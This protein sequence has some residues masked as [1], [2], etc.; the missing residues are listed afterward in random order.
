MLQ[1][2]KGKKIQERND[3]L[4][5]YLQ[6]SI[7]YGK[8]T[9]D[10]L[11]GESQKSNIDARYKKEFAALLWLPFVVSSEDG[12]FDSLAA[13]KFLEYGE[14]F[15][16]EFPDVEDAIWMEK[17]CLIPLRKILADDKDY[18]ANPLKKKFYTG[19]LGLEASAIVDEYLAPFVAASI[20]ILRVGVEFFWAFPKENDDFWGIHLNYTLWDSRYLSFCHMRGW[21]F[22]LAKVGD[23]LLALLRIFAFMLRGQ[24]I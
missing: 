14:S 4:F 15:V 18:M 6:H 2:P 12:R 22:L 7:G 13:V 3:S 23:R 9:S 19:G 1:N 21:G 24:K 11:I 10:S 17:E 8:W 5:L 20:Q 16:R